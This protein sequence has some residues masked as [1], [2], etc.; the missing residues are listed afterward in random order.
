MEN[1]TN[2]ARVGEGCLLV[3]L[4]S[5]NARSERASSGM[6][7][8]TRFTNRRKCNRLILLPLSPRN[9][10]AILSFSPSTSGPDSP[11]RFGLLLYMAGRSSNL[12]CVCKQEAINR[13]VPSGIERTPII[14]AVPDATSADGPLDRR[15]CSRRSGHRNTGSQLTRFVLSSSERTAKRF[16][17]RNR[18]DSSSRVDASGSGTRAM[19]W[20]R[21]AEQPG[22]LGGYRSSSSHRTI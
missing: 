8:F 4:L 2:R 11:I 19:S 10:N 17:R 1:Q 15:K 13:Q 7:Y 12:F 9:G 20:T 18:D 22:T 6:R 16:A 21:A 5:N 14:P 3:E